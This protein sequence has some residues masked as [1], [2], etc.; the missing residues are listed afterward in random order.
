MIKE[1]VN[2]FMGGMDKDT[3]KSILAKNKYIDA[4]NYRLITTDG[5]TTGSLENI[6]GTKF[7][8]NAAPVVGTN[9]VDGFIIG[10]VQLREDIILFVTTN[11]G[12]AP[13]TG[14][15]ISRIY[16]VTINLTTETQTGLVLLYDDSLNVD[17]SDLNFSTEHPIK[18]I[19]KYE[20]PNIQKVYWTDGYNN[21]RYINVVNNQTVDGEVYSV[22][23]DYMSVDKFEFLPK[24][25]VS[26]P[27][28][29]NIVGGK[30][31]TGVVAYAYQLY[32]TNG[33]ATAF[34]PLSDP[35]HVVSDNDFLT[36]TTNY[37]GD[38]T[39]INSGKG[40]ILSI[41]NTANTGYNR[42]RLIRVHYT[43]LNN[44]PEISI[45]NEIEINPAGTTIQVTDT[46]NTLGQ[47]TLDEFNVS[48]TELFKCQ[49]IATKNNKLFAANIGESS[50]TIDNTWDA[51]AV[52]FNS[53][54]SAVIQ[55]SGLGSR[56]LSGLSNWDDPSTGYPLEHDGI[57][58][59]NDPDNDGDPAHQYMFQ[60]NGTI[61]GA[62]G[63]N[64]KIDFETDYFVLD[65][66]N[67]DTTFSATPP[68][69]YDIEDL[70]YKNYASPWKGGKLSWQRDETYRLFVVFGNDRGQRAFPQ[71]ITDLRMPSLHDDN[72]YNSSSE[73]VTPSLLATYSV[74][75]EVTNSTRLYPRVLFKS[76]PTN[77]TW[78][79]IYRV[80]RERPDRSV[81]T[82]A[83][84][85][86]TYDAGSNN[87]APRVLT[88]I[89]LTT[90]G[91]NLV[92]LVSPEININKNIAKQA[93]DYIEYVGDFMVGTSY[94]GV[95]DPPSLGLGVAKLMTNSRIPWAAMGR[96]NITDSIL[97]S[98]K[99]N[100]TEYDV[101]NGKNY[102]NFNVETYP[103][104]S[105]KGSTGLLINYENDNF[106]M[107]ATLYSVINYKSNVY[108]SQYG[109]H[110][111]EDRQN[112][113][114]IPCSDIIKSTDTNIW[115]DISYGDTFINYFDV[116]TFLADLSIDAD[117]LNH[118]SLSEAAY[119]PLESS[120]NTDLMHD[121]SSA[122]MTFLTGD[123]GL[124]QEYAGSHTMK[125]LNS[126]D[127]HYTQEKDLYLYNT[128]YSQPLDVQ[129]AI[130]LT[131]DKTMETEFDCMIKVS[132]TKS[133]GEITDSW[134]IFGIN[135]YI[136][137]DSIYGPVNAINTFNDKL[138]YF[139]DKGFGILAVNDRS[140]ISDNSSSQLVL[141]TGGVLDRYDYISTI[142][143]CKDKFALAKGNEGLFWYDRNSNGVVKYSGS[144][145]KISLSKGI[146]SY[147][148]NNVIPT[149]LVIAHPDINN[150][151]ILFTF[152]VGG[153]GATSTSFTLAY[154][155]N[156][157]AFVSFYS[158]I[159]NIYIPFDNRYLSTT[160]SK[161]CN[162][163]FNLNYLF[164]HDSD[165]YPR[166]NFYGLTSVSPATYYDST[167]KLLYNDNYL[168]TKIWDNIFYMSN[169][170]L[171]DVELYNQTI[172]S[173]RCYNDF[174]NTDYVT[175]VY[176][177]SVA[178]KERGWALSIPRN[179]VKLDVTGNPNIFT[180]DLTD[181]TRLFRERL[182]DKYMIMDLKFINGATRDK[183]V[184]SN[185]G[186][187]YRLSY[188]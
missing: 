163:A 48:S 93:N 67:S 103:Y 111:Y 99:L 33:A 118:T 162:A 96:S 147:L 87:Y 77:A 64:I 183:F 180:S 184:L 63:K 129:F 24:F 131:T 88:N 124:R 104:L 9:V 25:V 126:D 2:T 42:L 186:A 47:L 3:D 43:S 102:Y 41:N 21:I 182:R 135:D 153:T 51:R 119:V 160:R 45:A 90:D 125:K 79:Q 38:E 66:S 120:I 171:N 138:F 19:A 97:L 106:T 81:V 16:K 61:L 26:K 140:L 80:K 151:E 84:A 179:L 139:Q 73:E 23:G 91:V 108:A 89:H 85:I 71:W 122:H 134:T 76:F 72:F 170:Y 169:A 136:E 78:A 173:I 159:P 46:G 39:K 174:Q 11:T 117:I 115:I 17:A 53:V 178:R 68:N 121:T 5:S 105:A 92:K 188:R 177:T 101:I 175:L 82:Q 150:N 58:T 157:E 35:I 149:Q 14:D 142:I 62:E 40:F 98:P 107:E 10:S 22:P 18:A 57:N 32:I 166:C 141:G 50:F 6:K 70:S 110:T 172:D 94:T 137:V 95:G 176:P 148:N 161:Y 132:H 31:N 55:D 155:E 75:A 54:G 59:F 165:I 156:I 152:F 7:L 56:T 154:S 69:V 49:D 12:T 30:V 144:I 52:R 167:I 133:N 28:L 100:E 168:E 4:L 113:V 15:G 112:N 34:S 1:T 130:P 83:L 128:V 146:Q 37:R 65:T 181:T 127:Y 114:S 44:V 116:S 185:V 60:A 29:E 187:K 27:V 145:D 109:G 36:N 8:L 164:L 86:P 20:T 74:V 143:G 13:V 158:F 123:A